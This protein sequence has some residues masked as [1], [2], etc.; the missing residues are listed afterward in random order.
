MIY[1]RKTSQTTMKPSII[2]PVNCDT[3]GF[4]LFQPHLCLSDTTGFDFIN[5]YTGLFFK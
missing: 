3:V 2:P 5:P 1:R 4:D